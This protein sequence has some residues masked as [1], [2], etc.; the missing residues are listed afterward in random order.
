MNTNK[1]KNSKL[2]HKLLENSI[3]IAHYNRDKKQENDIT[4]QL[5]YI[6]RMNFDKGHYTLLKAWSKIEEKNNIQLILV[7]PDETNGELSRLAQNDPSVRFTGSVPNVKDFLNSSTIGLFPS[8]KEGLPLALLEM[9]AYE[10]PIIVSDIPE[11]TSI[12]EDSVE[13][14]HA[15]LDDA[16]DLKDTILRLLN[17]AQLCEQLGKKSRQKVEEICKR[18]NPIHFHENFYRE[19]IAS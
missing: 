19:L 7:G 10:L 13:G 14:L 3:D 15:K 9:M 5:I 1:L 18:N 2:K 11:L 4:H 6:S 17:N 12:I 8:R 16:D